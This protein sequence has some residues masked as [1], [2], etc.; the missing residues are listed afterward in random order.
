MDRRG[1]VLLSLG[2]LLGAL[3][4]A[5]TFDFNSSTEEGA[6]N[7][8]DFPDTTTLEER[9]ARLEDAVRSLE[10][11]LD[12]NRRADPDHPN[13]RVTFAPGIEQKAGSSVEPERTTAETETSPAG[14]AQRMPT[15]EFLKN[16]GWMDV[17]PGKLA[18]ILVEH[19]MTPFDPG[20]RE[21]LPQAAERY[22]EIVRQHSLDFAAMRGEQKKFRRTDPR[23]LE[24]A[25][26]MRD[27]TSNRDRAIDEIATAF[28]AQVRA[29]AF[30]N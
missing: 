10:Q 4:I 5:V 23:A 9:L 17:V 29:L 30:E 25:Q 8:N 27:A 15:V 21:F 19:G 16:L 26:I 1:L 12:A 6:G 2:L 22:R 14:D 20:V 7:A 11:T 24:L 18:S 3:G 13:R 28:R